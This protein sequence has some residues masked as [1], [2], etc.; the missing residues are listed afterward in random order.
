MAKAKKS[1]SKNTRKT[2]KVEIDNS[3]DDKL[4]IYCIKSKF[5]D[6]IFEKIISKLKIRQSNYK[7]S[8]INKIPRNQS[9]KIMYKNLTI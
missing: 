3:K 9:E 8:F 2:F 5:S 6:R 7:L 1:T 4:E